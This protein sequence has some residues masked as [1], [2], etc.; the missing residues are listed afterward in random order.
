M[1][2]YIHAQVF[3]NLDPKNG[4]SPQNF[5]AKFPAMPQAGQ[6]VIWDQRRCH[7]VDLTWELNGMGIMELKVEINK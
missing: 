5:F 6:T 7:I 3:T 2:E 1:S 4:R